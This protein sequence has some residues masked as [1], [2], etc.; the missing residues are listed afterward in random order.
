MR[1]R[2]GAPATGA[3]YAARVPVT[4]GPDLHPDVASLAFL[5]GRWEG[6]GTGGYPTVGS[7]SYGEEL[8]FSHVGKPYVHY[9]QRTWSLD[10]GRPL[11]AETGYLRAGPDGHAELLVAEPLGIVEVLEGTCSGTVL[12]LHSVLV[13]RTST[14]KK[15]SAVSRRLAVEGS[16]LRY[17][18]AMEAVGEELQGHLRGELYHVR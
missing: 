10:D 9:A 5:L 7:F 3:I 14:A 17:E 15:V 18:L 8:R 2:T 12:D 1:R 11:H 6:E 16:V 4:A 13:G